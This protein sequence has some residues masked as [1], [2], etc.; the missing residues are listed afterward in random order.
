MSQSAETVSKKVSLTC[1]YSLISVP[2]LGSSQSRNVAA[3]LL[4][5]STEAWES[6][7]RVIVTE[8]GANR[9]FECCE[10][11]LMK[12]NDAVLFTVVTELIFEHIYTVHCHN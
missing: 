11:F 9:R 10:R 8:D 12:M 2:I 5:V 4:Q 3:A 6:E 7:A 1:V